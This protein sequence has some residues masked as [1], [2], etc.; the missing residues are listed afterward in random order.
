MAALM[1]GAAG[2]RAVEAAGAIAS[3]L[4]A[5]PPPP[6]S[7]D[8]AP[9][10]GGT[11][12]A[13]LFF[14]ALGEATGDRADTDLA[15]AILDEAVARV[16]ALE[17]PSIGLYGAPVGLAWADA[18]LRP[19]L[20]PGEEDG[21]TDVDRFVGNALAQD[22]WPWPND[23]L[24]GLAGLGT[25]ALA[26]L[27]HDSARATLA[28]VVAH[29]ANLAEEDDAGVAWRFVPVPGGPFRF[30]EHR[31]EGNVNVGFAHG[32]PAIVTFL[33]AAHRAG[34]AGAGELLGPAVRWLVAQRL[35]AGERSAFPA[36]VVRGRPA[37]GT[38]LA[39]CYGDPGVAVALL[40][41]GDALGDSDLVALA[42]GV[43]RGCG[44]RTDDGVEAAML[45]HGSAGLGHLFHRLGRALGDERLLDLA[46]HWFG[47]A[48]DRHLPGLLV[49]DR[50]R[51]KEVVAAG[52][53]LAVEPGYGFLSGAAGAGL[54]LLSAAS[55]EEPWWDGALFVQPPGTWPA[56]GYATMGA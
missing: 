36:Y 29:L 55:G 28:R 20:A 48:L 3:A 56:R 30:T 46:R 40:A 39:W 22:R 13:A 43:A 51:A 19:R 52:G 17:Q 35:P 21:E 4:R 33:A 38:R 47:V 2:D 37:T 7:T 15:V 11:L 45:C 49:V 53:T 54:A 12:G 50:V 9:T 25:Y 10:L 23:L 27:P 26:R 42:G 8:A 14:T 44:A 1:A 16:A 31:P 6:G 32:V 41:A 5:A 24:H 18:V 34:V